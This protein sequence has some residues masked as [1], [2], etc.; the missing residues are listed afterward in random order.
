MIGVRSL[1]FFDRPAVLKAVDR[2]ERRQLARFGAFVRRAARQSIRRT[3]K[4]SSRP[5]RPPNTQT[6]LI[7]NAILFAYDPDA[8]SVV[9]GPVRAKSDRRTGRVVTISRAS[10]VWKL[11]EDGGI[12]RA[13]DTRTGKGRTMRYRPRPYMG[14]AFEKNLARMPD[15]LRDTVRR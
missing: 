12:V 2:A 8:A 1:Q 14:P 7:K 9:I 6:G 11:L 3:K 5:G 13:R 15:M 10:G 4:K